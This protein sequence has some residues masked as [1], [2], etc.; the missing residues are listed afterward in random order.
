MTIAA[1]LLAT[2]PWIHG[3]TD[4]VETDGA[5]GGEPA[6]LLDDDSGCAAT[7][8]A[9]L[10]LSADIAPAAGRELIVAT[11]EGGIRV[12]SSEGV[13]LAASAGYPCFGSADA[14]EVLAVG[15]IFRERTIVL[16]FTSGGFNS[17]MTW[18]GAYRIGF[19]GSIDPL[20]AGVVETR[21]DGIVRTG[22]VTFIP[23]ALIYRPP[24]APDTLW[25][26]DPVAN[27][28]VPRGPFGREAL[29]H[30]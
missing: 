12:T 15:S 10:R 3:L 1:L 20:F 11:Y 17:Q 25:V 8:Q 6:W 9:P 29:P 21:E 26:F 19:G 5:A 13:Q 24:G 16:A 30:S 18:V 14:L 22:R 7:P 27:A 2:L 23:G 4:V 28:Y